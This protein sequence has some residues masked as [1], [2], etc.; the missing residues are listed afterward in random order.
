MDMEL[1]C[2]RSGNGS[3]ITF[4]NNQR[5]FR[6]KHIAKAHRD[7]CKDNDPKGSYHVSIG[8]DHRRNRD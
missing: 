2:V 5:F 7:W 8:P 3:I 4:E 6:D 1:F